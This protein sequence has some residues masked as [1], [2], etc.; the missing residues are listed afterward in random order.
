MQGPLWKSALS[1][2][3]GADQL[4]D[5]EDVVLECA[6]ELAAACAREHR[7]LARERVRP[8]AAGRKSIT[9]LV[10]Q[11]VPPSGGGCVQPQPTVRLVSPAQH[12][13]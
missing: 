9:V 10:P 6:L 7:G 3:I 4:G 2:L 1:A 13:T 12:V 8:G 11:G 5:G